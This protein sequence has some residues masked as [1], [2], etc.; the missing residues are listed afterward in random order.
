MQR[1]VRNALARRVLPREAVGKVRLLCAHENLELHDIA[2]DEAGDDLAR[3]VEAM[4]R[5]AVD[6]GNEGSEGVVVV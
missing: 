6:A 1:D 5:G 3:G 4:Y 2:H